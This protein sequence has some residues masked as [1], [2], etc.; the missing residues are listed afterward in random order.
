MK[1]TV[2]E[3]KSESKSE[4][5]SGSSCRVPGD[6]HCFHYL[7]TIGT[8][9][10]QKTSMDCCLCGLISG[11]APIPPELKCKYGAPM[12]VTITETPVGTTYHTPAFSPVYNIPAEERN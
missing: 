8:S 5:K 4:N 2:S 12:P 1:T 7:I 6:T 3:N 9:E 11:P 10:G